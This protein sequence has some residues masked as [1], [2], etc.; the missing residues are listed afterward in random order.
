MSIL[1]ELLELIFEYDRQLIQSKS[2]C[3][4]VNKCNVPKID[5]ST[6]WNE[7]FGYT[8][9]KLSIFY[10]SYGYLGQI[11]DIIFNTLGYI[12]GNKLSKLL[13]K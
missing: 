4:L 13:I 12:I 3:K 10:C 2:L 9:N 6:F 1:W 11:T 5:S 8:N 7:Y